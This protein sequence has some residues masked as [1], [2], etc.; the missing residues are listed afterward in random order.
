MAYTEAGPAEQTLGTHRFDLTVD[1]LLHRV[2]LLARYRRQQL[3]CTCAVNAVV[4]QGNAVLRV[5]APCCSRTGRRSGS[6]PS[7]RWA[8]P[9]LRS[10]TPSPAAAAAAAAEQQQTSSSRHSAQRRCSVPSS[11]AATSC[12]TECVFHSHRHRSMTIL[13]SMQGSAAQ[14][15]FHPCAF[16]RRSGMRRTCQRP[17]DGASRASRSD[18]KRAGMSPAT[19]AVRRRSG[20]GGVAGRLANPAVFP[21]RVGLATGVILRSTLCPATVLTPAIA[22]SATPSCS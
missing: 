15:Q 20:H 21:S 18:G 11:G 22:L 6:S 9:C 1:R 5:S 4:S 10:P 13:V 17:Y 14:R 2:G 12:V 3:T 16:R 8:W 19:D 7:A